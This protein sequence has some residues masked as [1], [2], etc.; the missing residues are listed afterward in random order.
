MREGN[1]RKTY[2]LATVLAHDSIHYSAALS[3]VLT[4]A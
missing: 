3:L 4:A 1:T 2:P